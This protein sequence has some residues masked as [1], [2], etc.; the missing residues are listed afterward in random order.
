VRTGETGIELRVLEVVVLERNS[1]GLSALL[2][3]GALPVHFQDVDMVGEAVE[4]GP[5]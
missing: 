1:F 3:A 2:E 5:R 4:K